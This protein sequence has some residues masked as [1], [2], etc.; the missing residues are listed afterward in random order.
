MKSRMGKGGGVVC[1]RTGK[2]APAI[3]AVE[4]MLNARRDMDLFAT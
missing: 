1:A 3:A 2:D 4:S